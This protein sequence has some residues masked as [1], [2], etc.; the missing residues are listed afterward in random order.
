MAKR[1]GTVYRIIVC[2]FLA[3]RGWDMKVPMRRSLRIL[4][5]RILTRQKQNVLYFLFLC[6]DGL[7]L[8]A[9]VDDGGDGS[10]SIKALYISSEA[11][12]MK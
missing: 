9:V 6:V 4:S 12:L 3:K 1:I 5:L 7:W 8:P 10:R 2:T 11:A